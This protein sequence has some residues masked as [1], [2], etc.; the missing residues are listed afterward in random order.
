LHAPGHRPLP[1]SPARPPAPQL[2]SQRVLASEWVH[3]VA[4][5]KVAQLPQEVRDDV[6]S[7]LL[8]LTLRELFDWHFMQVGGRMAGAWPGQVGWWLLGGPCC[9][10][11]AAQGMR[12]ETPACRV[13]LPAPA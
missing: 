4:I 13:L 5:D 9:C 1:F 12:W 7:R 11:S 2:S 3:G 6:G 10:R 8:Q